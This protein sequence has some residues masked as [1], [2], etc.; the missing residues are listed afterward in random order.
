MKET[1]EWHHV[2]ESRDGAD[3][4]KVVWRRTLDGKLFDN[5]HS[6][7]VA[8]EILQ[9][10][11]LEGPQDTGAPE[12]SRPGGNQLTIRNSSPED[13]DD[14][15]RFQLVRA[16][17]QGGQVESTNPVQWLVTNACLLVDELKERRNQE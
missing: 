13:R 8:P 9:W 1:I 4:D 3:P 14:E 10:A 6:G 2:N 5:D 7:Y 17:L 16:M 15:R 11:V 12:I